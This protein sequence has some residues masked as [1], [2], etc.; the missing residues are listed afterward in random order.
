MTGPADPSPGPSRDRVGDPAGGAAVDLLRTAMAAG[1]FTIAAG[2]LVAPRTF[3]RLSG[4]GPGTARLLGLRDVVVGVALLR[5][6][7]PGPLLARG[8]SDGADALA[9]IRRRPAIATFAAASAMAN[10]AGA[11]AARRPP[12]PGHRPVGDPVP[13]PPGA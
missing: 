13:F 1:S 10:L 11:V 3:G 8:L 12:G 2:A 5:V 6:G 7:G 4:V 9:L